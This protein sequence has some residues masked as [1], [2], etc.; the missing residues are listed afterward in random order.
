MSLEGC[1]KGV[2]DCGEKESVW[3]RTGLKGSAKR[4]EVS[5]SRRRRDSIRSLASTER[6]PSRERTNTTKLRRRGPSISTRSRLPRI[7][8]RDLR[9]HPRSCFHS[10]ILHQ[11][12]LQSLQLSLKL[13]PQAL[14][15]RFEFCFELRFEDGEGVGKRCVFVSSSDEGGFCERR[16]ERDR[17]QRGKKR[18]N[19]QSFYF[20]ATRRGYIRVLEGKLL[21][22]SEESFQLLFSSFHAAGKR[23]RGES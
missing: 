17:V 13:L 21:Q 14:E 23:P 2:A 5:S 11:A 7:L 3:G 15:L 16:E 10:S 19:S 20:D 18:R 6:G 12:L 1:K 9:T 4:R 8:R 22:P